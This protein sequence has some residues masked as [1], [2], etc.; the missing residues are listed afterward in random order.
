MGLGIGGGN[1]SGG[2]VTGKDVDQARIER[3]VIPAKMQME[4]AF[5]HTLKDIIQAMGYKSGN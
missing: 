4:E 2:V 5:F 3:N 1:S